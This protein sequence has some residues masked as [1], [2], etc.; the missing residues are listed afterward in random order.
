M[1]QILLIT[2][3]KSESKCPVE[4]RQTQIFIVASQTSRGSC[5]CCFFPSPLYE[6]LVK[7]VRPTSPSLSLSDSRFLPLSLPVVC[8][9]YTTRH[10]IPRHGMPSH[11]MPQ[12]ITPYSAKPR[13]ITPRHATPQYAM[14]CYSTPPSATPQ[15]DLGATIT[16]PLG[17]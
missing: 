7:F 6:K 17:R 3:H 8:C 4:N 16:A 11:V 1:V 13:H 9:G 14:P 12:S 10:A 15:H 5:F 2:A